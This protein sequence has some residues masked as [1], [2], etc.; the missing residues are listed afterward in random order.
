[1]DFSGL[2]Y[3]PNIIDD[4]VEYLVEEEFQGDMDDEFNELL[5][6][7][8]SN[9]ENDTDKYLYSDNTSDVAL[10]KYI[11]NNDNYDIMDCIIDHLKNND[12]SIQWSRI[13]ITIM[14]I[15]TVIR[16]ELTQEIEEKFNELKKEK[17]TCDKCNH[18]EKDE[19]DI[20]YPENWT[21]KYPMGYKLCSDC[22]N[23]DD[24]E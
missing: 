18:F 16:E 3:Y 15:Y 21:K 17:H 6:S 12:I 22:V 5:H 4:F 2:F 7:W 24:E 23:E 11:A 1:M 10:I 13:K 14:A 20:H 8:L 9:I 19:D